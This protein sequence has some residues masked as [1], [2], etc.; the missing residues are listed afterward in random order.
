MNYLTNNYEVRVQVNMKCDKQYAINETEKTLKT[1]GTNKSLGQ[2][3]DENCD[4]KKHLKS[5][6]AIKNFTVIK[7]WWFSSQTLN[8]YVISFITM[9]EFKRTKRLKR[10][11]K[12]KR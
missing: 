5:Y 11:K 10:Y 8:T 1:L 9:M 7:V 4:D 2:C 12:V 3:Y 6:K